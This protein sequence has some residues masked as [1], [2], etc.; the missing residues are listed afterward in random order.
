MWGKDQFI[1][2]IYYWENIQCLDTHRTCH[3]TLT[4]LL[5][6]RSQGPL[7]EMLLCGNHG[8]RSSLVSVLQL[9]CWDNSQQ[10][11][12]STDTKMEINISL[13]L[14][15][16]EAA[17]YGLLFT[18]IAS[19]RKWEN[20]NRRICGNETVFHFCVLFLL[21]STANSSFNL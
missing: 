5:F 21:S 13:I 4:D 1:A 15:Q 6:R 10:S 19:G 3:S 17:V 18:K 8:F 2:T 12:P 20:E 14:K 11:L 9:V 7:E 16:S